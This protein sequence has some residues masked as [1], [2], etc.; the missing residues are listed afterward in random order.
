ME[1]RRETKRQVIALRTMMRSK[2]LTDVQRTEVSTHID[3]LRTKLD[4]IETQ[5]DSNEINTRREFLRQ[6][7]GLFDVFNTFWGILLSFTEDGF[8]SKE[9]YTKFHHALEIVLA[10]LPTWAELDQ[11]SVDSDWTHDKLLY[12]SFNKQA[13]FDMLFETIGTYNFV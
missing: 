3:E 1:N 4:S 5:V 6:N 11:A 2:E 10:G 7:K 9:G 12:G 13:F 8:L